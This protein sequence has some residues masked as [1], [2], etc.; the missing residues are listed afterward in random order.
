M[1]TYTYRV[2][3]VCHAKKGGMCAFF[4]GEGW[5]WRNS[6]RLFT[7]C[8]NQT[9][10]PLPLHPWELQPQC[11]LHWTDGETEG[12]GIAAGSSQCSCLASSV[13]TQKGSDVA[14][15]EIKAKSS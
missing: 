11:F 4:T 2:P 8:P 6:D 3:A 10:L 14:L 1:V 5:N 13:V 12:R 15:V 9:Q 7:V